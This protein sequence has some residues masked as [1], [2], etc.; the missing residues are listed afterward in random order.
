MAYVDTIFNTSGKIPTDSDFWNQSI[1]KF[2][3][4]DG[5][6]SGFGRVIGEQLFK[7]LKSAYTPFYSRFAGAPI[8]AG[9]GW[10]ERALKSTKMKH[11][12][13]KATAEDALG[14]V[15]ST[16]V[17]KTFTQNVAGWSPVC[18]PSEL[19]SMEMFAERNGIGVL[20][21]QLVD[22]NVLTYQRA[23]ESEIEKKAVSLTKN[24]M[25]VDIATDGIIASIGAIMDKASEMMS[26]DAHF[27]ELTEAE[28]TDLITRSDKIYCFINQKYWNAYRN[29]K[30]SLPSPSELVENVEVVP[31]VNAIA[32]PITTA[33]FNAG[34]DEDKSWTAGDKPVAVD[35]PAPIAYLVASD[36]IVYRPVEGS[37]K[38]NLQSNGAGDFF[39]SHL[40]YKGAIAVRPWENAVRVNLKA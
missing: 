23:I 14:Y 13:P 17:E 34:P 1:D 5:I 18:V 26:D 30:A 20:N 24:E 9:M 10:T 15:D 21:S 32:K 36:K 19:V 28:N 4:S 31:M 39:K 12:K 8:S 29:A 37:Y 33:E 40:I 25:E 11:F 6:T 27:N 35:K 38:V 22:N 3:T 2:V 7:P 16:G